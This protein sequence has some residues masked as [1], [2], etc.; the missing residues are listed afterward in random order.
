MFIVNWDFIMFFHLSVASVSGTLWPQKTALDKICYF[1]IVY[2]LCQQQLL[3][4]HKNECEIKQQFIIIIIIIRSMAVELRLQTMSCPFRIFSI[5][6]F[7]FVMNFCYSA[8]NFLLLH[9]VLV[10][11]WNLPW[12]RHQ[13]KL[14]ISLAISYI[15]CSFVCFFIYPF[16]Y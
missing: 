11:Q 3:S 12:T 5:H 16:Q 14:L 15:V 8:L 9:I 4:S 2:C 13:K 7:Q 6:R 1:K 10:I